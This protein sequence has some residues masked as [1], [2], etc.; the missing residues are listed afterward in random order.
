MIRYENLPEQRPS[1]AYTFSNCQ[2]SVDSPGPL[3]PI[4]LTP[5]P[6]GQRLRH[7]LDPD[8]QQQEQRQRLPLEVSTSV[9]RL[10]GMLV[11]NRSWLHKQ[12]S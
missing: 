12:L 1:I 3:R 7:Q 10:Y 2:D 8:L 4:L 5:L 9:P 6:P 11:L